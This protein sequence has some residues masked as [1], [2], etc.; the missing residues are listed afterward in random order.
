MWNINETFLSNQ[1]K[2]GKTFI[3]SH[4]PATATGYFKQE[5]NFLEQKGFEFIK[6]GSTWKA[7]KN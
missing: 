3:L 5:V 7:I 4:D 2:E 1:L 6:E